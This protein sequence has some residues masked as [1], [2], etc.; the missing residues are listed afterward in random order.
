[1]L[2]N[3]SFG[4]YFKSAAI[5]YA[6]TF[7]TRELSIPPER[8]SVTVFGGDAQ[9]PADT[10]AEELWKKIGVPAKR[11]TRLGAKDNF[12][13]MG[14]TGP[15]GPCTEIHF[16]RGD[17]KGTFGGDDPGGDR[18]CE[19]WNIVFMQFD[20]QTDRSLLP[21]PAPSVD[22]G[23]G[24]ERLA[25]VMNGHASNYDT[26]L[27]RPL[28]AFSEERLKKT[29]RST[30]SADDV[31]MR[32]VADH[33]RTTAFLIADGVMPGNLNREYVL[34]SI[35]RRAIRFGDRLGYQDA[36]FHEVALQ[37]VQM[38]GAAYPELISAQSLI[39]KVVATEEAAFRATLGR[40]LMLFN[41]A[42][43]GFARG[44][45]LS[46]DVVFDLKATHGFPH[47]LTAQMARESGFEIDWDAFHKA[48]Q[49]HSEV[50]GGGLGV[51][52]TADVFKQ[53]R[54]E[55]GPT[56][57][58]GY[59]AHDCDAKVIA[60]L[61][62]GARVDVLAQGEQGFVVLDKSPLYGE[63]GGQVGDAG[64]LTA[65][66]LRV[67]IDDT[68]KQAELHLHSAYVNEG[69]LKLG[70]TV[71]AHVNTDA[72]ERTRRNHSATHLLHHALRKVLGDHVTQKGSLVAPDRLRFDFS[73]FDAMSS[74]QLSAVEDVV[75]G[76]V[77]D[78]V[79]ARVE[80][81]GVDEARHKGAMALFGEKYGERVRV[82]ELG[83][84]VELCGGIHVRRTGDIGLF[85]ITSE[86][87]LAAGV[88][89]IEA[90][91]GKGAIEH[92][93]HQAALLHDTARALKVGADEI[94]SRVEKLQESLRAAEKA[95]EKTH[96]QARSAAAGS[97]VGA[98]EDV[99]GIKLLAQRVNDV[100]PKNLR[101]YADK[102]RDQLKS[103]VVVLGVPTGPDSVTVL[104]A[105]T[106]DLVGRLNAGAMIKELAAVV[107]GKGGGKSDMAQA[108]GTLP[109]RLDD[110]FALARDLVA[111]AAAA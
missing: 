5:E 47:D 30:D 15:C 31:A 53:L 22:T 90:V 1:M 27:L 58:S 63:S 36:F 70:A 65:P 3:F 37:A 38:F 68:K 62:N 8:L 67:S 40:G 88:R 78:N 80:E 87:P 73:H 72:L 33:A 103:G 19:I 11:I 28:V 6:W 42:T 82:V 49:K 91:T 71:H 4:D 99:S 111:R 26:D 41:S 61:K 108:G 83:T 35:M 45:I 32:V 79:D 96:Q 77:L 13:Q 89:R 59:V 51:E 69:S 52:G 102:L 17:V 98:A 110:A 48:E 75:N 101:D 86:G 56:A 9:T 60:I 107:G 29:Y 76:L 7:L 44:A 21:L 2:G 64:T 50:S 18:V 74:E 39:E 84:S 104:V 16:D 105:L 93:R 24:L 43:A 95:L 20:R 92:V 25:M 94:P 66:G 54:T 57:F 34:R 23:M 14:D 55:L 100:D 85:K 12:W 46:G 10:E 109:A 106:S 97:A 81:L